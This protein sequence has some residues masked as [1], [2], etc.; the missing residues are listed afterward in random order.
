M[1]CFMKKSEQTLKKI[2]NLSSKR[3]NTSNPE[4]M[5][6]DMKIPADLQRMCLKEIDIQDCVE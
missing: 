6:I 5:S 1:S 2:S 4:D 3:L